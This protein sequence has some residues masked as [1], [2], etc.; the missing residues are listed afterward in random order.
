MNDV[1]PG[2]SRYI[3]DA[4]VIEEGEGEFFDL[5]VSPIDRYS[6]SLNKKPITLKG[7]AISDVCIG[8]GNVC[9]TAHNNV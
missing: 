4:F 7:F 6:F 9:V 2:K 5:S 3:L 1:Y 8:C